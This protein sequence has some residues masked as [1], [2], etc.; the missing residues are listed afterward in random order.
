[1]LTLFKRW[2]DVTSPAGPVGFTISQVGGFMLEGVLRHRVW[3]A[4]GATKL[5][6]GTCLVV[7]FALL[8]IATVKRLLDVGWP[9][10]WSVLVLGPIL[11]DVLSGIGKAESAFL[12]LAAITS[13]VI[14]LGY[15]ALVVVLVFRKQRAA[16]CSPNDT[17]P[18]LEELHL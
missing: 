12:K 9:R 11:L 10:S 13:G 14:C 4:E 15:L 7:M 2:L 18:K 3:T 8:A 16:G 17:T 5:L 1:M 6:W